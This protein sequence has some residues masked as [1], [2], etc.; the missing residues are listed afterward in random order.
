MSSLLPPN[1]SPLERALDSAI[2]ARLDA[3]D[4]G[5]IRDLW[6]AA[7]CPAALLPWL[8]WAWSVDDWDDAWP[9]AV[10]RL[11]VAGAIAVHRTKGTVGSIKR[12]VAAFGIPS[13][14]ITVDEQLHRGPGGSAYTWADYGITVDVPMSITTAR[15]MQRVLKHVAPAR[16]R[17]AYV[18]ANVR[19]AHDGSIKHTGDY[20]HGYVFIL[21]ET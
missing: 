19:I 1:A 3:V 20:T 18:R 13:S 17:L 7:A 10:K 21:S 4:P 14:Q 2:E 5:P 8:A 12:M 9:E 16:S 15:A 11:I 6:D